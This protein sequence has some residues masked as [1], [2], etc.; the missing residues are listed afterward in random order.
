MIN[1]IKT[2]TNAMDDLGYP[3]VS[4]DRRLA[5]QVRIAGFAIAR[6]LVTKAVIDGLRRSSEDAIR[7]PL[8]RARRGSTYGLRNLLQTMPGALE[9]ATSSEILGVVRDIL[10]PKARPVKGILFDK[11]EQANWAVPWHQ[12]VTIAVNARMNVPGYDAWS[13]KDGMPHVQPPVEVLANILAVRIHLDPCPAENGALKVI[14]GSHAQGR[15]G[16]ADVDH[17]KATIPSVICAADAGDVL[18]MRP[19]LLHS[20]AAA[21]T[22][23]H[24]RVIH[25]EYTA[26]QLPGGLEWGT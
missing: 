9:L 18:L 13:E 22:P 20:S 3:S 12:D 2:G 19:L 21:T 8:A 15:L 5:E 7:H 26:Y 16:D 4:N 23:A 11:T 25:V 17:W 1:S 10:G 6:G 14:P 24:R